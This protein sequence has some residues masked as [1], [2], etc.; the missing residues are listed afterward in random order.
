M[1]E[2]LN[3][4]S[5]F[6]IHVES[7]ISDARADLF[8]GMS[9]QRQQD[10]TTFICGPLPDQTALHSILIRLRDMNIKIISVNTVG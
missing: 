5:T 9:I 10:G 7:H 3:S 2:Q 4:P 6:E 1:D 8:E